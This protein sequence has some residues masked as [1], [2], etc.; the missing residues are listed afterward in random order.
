[1][2]NFDFRFIVRELKSLKKLKKEVRLFYVDFKKTTYDYF[3]DIKKIIFELA[4]FRCS[5]F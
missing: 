5:F 3:K 1:M 2:L 4:Y